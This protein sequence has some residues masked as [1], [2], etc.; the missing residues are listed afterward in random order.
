MII[1]IITD[2]HI[3]NEKSLNETINY[4][5]IHIAQTK[6]DIIVCLGDIFDKITTCIR[7]AETFKNECYKV[8]P[9]WIFLYGNHDG[10]Y[11][12]NNEVKGWHHFLKIF[13]DAQARVTI[14]GQ[15]FISVADLEEESNHQDF[16]LNNVKQNDIILSH[17]PFSQRLLNLLE[18]KGAALALNGHTHVFHIQTGEFKKLRQYAMPCFRIGGMNNEPACMSFVYFENKKIK[19]ICQETPL[20]RFNKPYHGKLRQFDYPEN[21]AEGFIDQPSNWVFHPPLKKGNF[22]WK[23]GYG[24]LQHFENNSLVWDK[25]YGHPHFDSTPLFPFTHNNTEYL[26][27]AGTWGKSEAGGDFNSAVIID[28]YSGNVHLYLPLV[29]LTAE[30]ILKDGHLYI[31]GQWHEVMA[32]D[33]TAMKIIWENTAFVSHPTLE[34]R[35]NRTGGGWGINKPLVGEHVWAVNLRGDL[36]G[37]DKKSGRRKFIHHEYIQEPSSIAYSPILGCGSIQSKII[38]HEKGIMQF[39]D[40]LICDLTG[41]KIY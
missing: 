14:Q 3:Y 30:P 11:P 1:G 32:I 26:V 34:W 33:L 40:K 17:G 5:K 18:E 10:E 7:Y 27:V 39:A 29:G 37:Y 13:P 38:D 12:S 35:D 41:E 4:L 31:V 36:I 6:P 8:F 28:A 20:P 15:G 9:T 22:S 25:S 23:G 16:L 2:I 19:V 21:P 24:R